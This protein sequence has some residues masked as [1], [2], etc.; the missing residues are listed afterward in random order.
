MYLN[1][2]YTDS[3]NNQLNKTLT[4]KHQLTGT[5]RNESN[6]V[7]PMILLEAL[8]IADSNYAYIEEFQR[9]YY[10]KEIESIRNGLWLIS[11]ESDPLMSFKNDILNLEVVLAEC[12]DNHSNSYLS[13]NRVWIS[14]NKDRTS[15]INFPS[16]LSE[17]GENILITS[18]GW[19]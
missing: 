2:Y 19:L 15:I 11:L 4:I 18:G 17:S 1:L 3:E 16:G 5:L 7:R 9:Y 14:S 10:I 8:S 6:V 12:E 13:D